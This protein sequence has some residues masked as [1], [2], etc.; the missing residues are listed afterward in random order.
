V[1]LSMLALLWHLVRAPACGGA[2]VSRK[3][4]FGGQWVCVR[5][6][7]KQIWW[8]VGVHAFAREPDLVACG[9]ACVS[10][11]SGVGG[12]WACMLMQEKRGWWHVGVH[13][14]AR[15]AGLVACGRACLC[16]RS[17][18]SGAVA[19]LSHVANACRGQHSM[20]A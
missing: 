18:V 14:Y 10:R 15:E 7:E 6:Q 19:P 17:G 13:A 5:L 4:G 20:H 9:R 2:Y 11:R 1:P 12:M 8:R 16:T 3:S